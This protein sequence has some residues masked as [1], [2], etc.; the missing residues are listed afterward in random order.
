[1]NTLKQYIRL[2]AA[3]V[4]SGIKEHDTAFLSSSWCEYLTSEVVSYANEHNDKNIPN[5][6]DIIFSLTKRR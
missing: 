2:G 1:M 3:I 6:F 5:N 4:T